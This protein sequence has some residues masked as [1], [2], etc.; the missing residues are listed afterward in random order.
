MNNLSLDDLCLSIRTSNA[1]KQAEIL[2]LDQLLNTTVHVLRSKIRSIG[3]KCIEEIR[4]KLA[5]YGLVLA[6]ETL[7]TSIR[8]IELCKELPAKLD[9]IKTEL[10]VISSKIWEL[11][12]I[13]EQI[14]IKER[15]DKK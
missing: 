14:S 11:H 1:L 10:K 6:G 9:E 12:R 5:Y 3:E 7:I 15:K 8:G 2:T 4:I 13:I